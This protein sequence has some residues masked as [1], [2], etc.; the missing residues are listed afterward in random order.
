MPEKH[1]TT[2]GRQT[3][4]I[5]TA[6]HVVASATPGARRQDAPRQ[7]RVL[8]GE[9]AGCAWTEQL[10]LENS[11]SQSFAGGAFASS[12]FGAGF[13]PPDLSSPIASSSSTKPP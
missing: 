6:R 4:E 1:N 8:V 10:A 11:G 9:D 13:L 12:C 3:S 5:D 7:G 2:R